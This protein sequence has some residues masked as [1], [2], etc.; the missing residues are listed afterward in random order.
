VVCP[1]PHEIQQDDDRET[2]ITQKYMQGKNEIRIETAESI[3][4]A[5]KNGFREG[6]CSRYFVNGNPVSSYMTLIRYIAEEIHL[7][8]SSLVPDGKKL[9]E[10]RRE[11]LT[12]QNNLMKK[13]LESLKAEYGQMHVPDHVM[14]E[15]D[16]MIQKIDEYGVRVHE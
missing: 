8:K 6:E 3:E 9:E 10:L 4:D 12:S 16:S 11:M 1:E 15:L 13:N 14:K 7:N 2:M 5:K